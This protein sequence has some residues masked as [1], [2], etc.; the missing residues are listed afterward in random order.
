[1][2]ILFFTI[3][4]DVE[5]NY[6]NV[7]KG[8]KTADYRGRT[9]KHPRPKFIFANG[10]NIEN[11]TEE[12]APISVSYG[13]IAEVCKCLMLHGGQAQIR[14]HLVVDGLLDTDRLLVILYRT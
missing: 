13:Y 12:A 1:M 6:F 2:N 3:W 4:F 9:L 8:R 11:S 5:H 7:M 14:I 10:D